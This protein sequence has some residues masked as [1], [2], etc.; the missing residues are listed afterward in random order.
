MSYFDVEEEEKKFKEK[1]PSCDG[2]RKEFIDCITQSDCFQK[3]GKKIRECLHPEA[4]GV[5]D[6][7]RQIQYTFFECK[8]SLVD[9]RMRFRGRKG[10]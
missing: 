7:C 10:Y 9:M 1:H 4:T 8:R 5:S 6:E 3:E 2:L